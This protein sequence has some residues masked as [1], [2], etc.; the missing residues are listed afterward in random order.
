LVLTTTRPPFDEA[1]SEAVDEAFS[2]LGESAKQATYWYVTSKHGLPKD[3]LG[4]H[5]DDFAAALEGFFLSG[6]SVMEMLILQRLS[7]LTGIK[8][9]PDDFRQF[10]DTV[11]RIRR[12]VAK[13]PKLPLSRGLQ[14]EDNPG[15][16]SSPV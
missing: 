14:M 2:C 10:V 11:K 13:A 12:M 16:E 6:S 8:L 5:V 9:D 4:S 1:F 15:R 7:S 3:E